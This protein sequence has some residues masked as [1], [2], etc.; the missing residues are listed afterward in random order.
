[1]TSHRQERIRKRLSDLDPAHLEI[2]NESDLHAGPPGRETHLKI[3]M[4]ADAFS[5]LSR[6]QRHQQVTSML[7]AELDSGLHALTMRLSTVAEWEN[8]GKRNPF[9]SPPCAGGEKK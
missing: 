1:M 8:G 2:I 5:G 7:Q 4:V 9:Q 3:L 6:V